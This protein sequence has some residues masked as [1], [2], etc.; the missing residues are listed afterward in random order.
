MLRLGGYRGWGSGM[1]IGSRVSRMSTETATSNL[2]HNVSSPSLDSTSIDSGVKTH[3]LKYTSPL[4]RIDT[5]S[6]IDRM[7]K[8][9]NLTQDQSIALMDCFYD[10]LNSKFQELGKSLVS[11]LQVDIDS[12]MLKSRIHE[13][14]LEL[15]TLS[16]KNAL[17]AKTLHE[18]SIGELQT[19]FEK[20][21]DATDILQM[22]A[23]MRL[24]FYKAE[25]REEL[26]KIDSIY[27]QGN[28]HLTVTMSDIKTNVETVKLKA[29]YSF[30]VVLMVMFVM[31]IFERS[32]YK[33]KKVG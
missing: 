13:I 3:R 8:T 2:I 30:T 7:K 5:F 10:I 6:L 23:K 12:S 25:N 1:R 22:D 29:I 19:L 17:E 32:L 16:N 24:H 9:G 33:D 28:G 18:K 11:Q 21:R 31:I 14:R 20:L 4:Q 26:S 15:Q 27:R